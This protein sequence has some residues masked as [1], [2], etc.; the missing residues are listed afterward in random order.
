MAPGPLPIFS[1]TDTFSFF[2]DPNMLGLNSNIQSVSSTAVPWPLLSLLS[3]SP[4]LCG[5][6]YLTGGEALPE[7]PF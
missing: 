3:E 2:K 5:L 6:I 4:W 7:L 1:Y